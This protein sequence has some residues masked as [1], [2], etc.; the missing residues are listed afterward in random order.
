MPRHGRKPTIESGKW[1]TSGILPATTGALPV[2][3]HEVTQIRPFAF[4][5]ALLAFLACGQG[6]VVGTA[7]V[8]DSAG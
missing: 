1:R 2:A 7:Q 3:L 8:T 6:T 5:G 4:L